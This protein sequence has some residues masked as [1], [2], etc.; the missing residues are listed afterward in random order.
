MNRTEYEH[1]L[2]ERGEIQRLLAG[3]PAESVLVRRS[4]LARL[5]S[6]EHRLA[7]VVAAPPAP[8]RARLTFRGRPVVGG[9]G[10]FAE[11]GLK[12][13]GDFVGAVT[14]MTATI[15]GVRSSGSAKNRHANQLLIT[16]TAICSF[17]FALEEY[18][19]YGDGHAYPEHEQTPVVLALGQTLALLQATLGSDDELTD[20]VVSVDR[21][22]M[23]AVRTFLE[24]LV[25]NEAVCALELDDASVS[26]RD[27]SDV[28]RSLA[29][30]SHGNIHEEVQSFE[31]QI[32]G[33]LPKL[34]TF[35]FKLTDS[36]EVIAGRIGPGIIDPDALNQHL[37]ERARLQ[38]TAV[39]VG[40][41]RPRFVLNE[42]PEWLGPSSAA[43]GQ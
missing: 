37:Y 21:T 29:R 36:G 13:T 14:A 27:V 20:A 4:F 41:A 34:R 7:E 24:T 42:Q 23:A 3:I 39:L 22:A 18:R 1:L 28:R 17:G 26:F 19:E 31:G 25:T 2:A 35:E 30:L 38:V 16:S 32:R 8:A 33:I 9:H 12:A 5:D 6:V 10:I 15:P 40:A 43:A 11:F